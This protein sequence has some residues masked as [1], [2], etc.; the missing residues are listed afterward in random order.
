M[1]LDLDETLINFKFNSANEN[2]GTLFLRPGLIDFLS[3]VRKYYEVVSFT[4]GTKDYAE[5]ILDS[6]ETE[7]KFFDYRL[8]REHAVIIGKDFVK[9]ISRIGR[10]MSRIVIVDNMAMNFRLN[11]ENGILIYPYY[12]QDKN[13][14]SLYELRDI[15]LKMAVEYTDIRKG[16]VK[17]R[18][19]ICLKVSSNIN[20]L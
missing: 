14:T 9:D 2:S 18:N 5:P 19:E 20:N 11:K 10:D 6:I 15:L 13:D 16:L 3:S 4:A 1:V 7:E 17:Y 8:Y 12:F